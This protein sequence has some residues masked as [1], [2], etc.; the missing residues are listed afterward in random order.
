MDDNKEE[1]KN[2][3]FYI[4]SG[5]YR[6]GKRIYIRILNHQKINIIYKKNL[7][8]NQMKNQM[9]KIIYQKKHLALIFLYLKKDIVFIVYTDYDECKYMWHT[10]FY[11]YKDG[12]LLYLKIFSQIHDSMPFKITEHDLAGREK[13]H[14]SDIPDDIKSINNVIDP[15]LAEKINDEEDCNNFFIFIC[16]KDGNNTRAKTLNSY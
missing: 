9:K 12:E 10:D 14:Y 5:D 7:M 16:D 4:S 13:G 6:S 2:F 11:S 8:K 3:W 15:T 1:R